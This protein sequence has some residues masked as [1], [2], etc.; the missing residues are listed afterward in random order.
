MNTSTKTARL[1]LSAVMI[2]ISIA[3]SAICSA[4]P[5]FNLPFGGGFTVASMLP[6]ILVAYMYGVKWG[7]LTGFVYSIM[8]MLLGYNTVTSFFLPGDSQMVWYI[9]IIVCLI[10]YVIAYTALGLGGIFR[11]KLGKAKAICIGSIV[12]LSVRYIAHIVSGAIFFGS[13]A[14][15]FFTQD[16]FPAFG[17]TIVNTFSGNALSIVYSIF[18][19]GTY[20][21]P[22]II[23]TSIVAVAVSRIKEIKTIEL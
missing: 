23:I 20:M 18:Y 5:F 2:A 4:V 16:G 12:T 8:Q 10:D 22:E 3:I 14:E 17:Q 9:A 19:N 1:T 6:I 11:N 15:W 7:L 21:I 13:W